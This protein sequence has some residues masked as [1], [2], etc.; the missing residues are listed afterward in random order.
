MTPQIG[1]API[2]YGVYGDVALP[3][4]GT[5][6]MLKDLSAAGYAGSEL[7][8]PTL[9][10]SPSQTQSL[11]NSFNLECAG[12]Y[13]PIHFTGSDELFQSD[14]EGMRLT[15]MNLQACSALRAIVADEGSDELLAK[16]AHGV[17][18]QMTPSQWKVFFERLVQVVAEIRSH[19]LE[20]SFHPHIST[21]IESPEEI[22][23]LLAESDVALTFDTGHIYLGGGD[24]V[25]CAKRWLD[26]ID[27][28]HVKDVQ[29][30]VM[31]TAIAEGRTDFNTWWVDVSVPLG[32]GDVDLS[33]FLEVLRSKPY[34]GWLVVEQDRAPADEASWTGI[35]ETQQKNFRWL[36]NQVH[37]NDSASESA[38]NRRP[39]EGKENV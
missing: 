27:H 30:S 26:R 6:R 5:E 3:S 11:F 32:E 29:A 35:A 18:L 1:N 24:V 8:P 25:E 28:V 7:G 9:F 31:T 16:P 36:W 33:G 12:A 17:E 2:S 38:A 14:L 10:G 39:N 19:D 20:A 22:D 13:V 21:Y 34:E 37:R 15:L 23:R 4:G